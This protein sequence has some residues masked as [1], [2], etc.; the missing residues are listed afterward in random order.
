MVLT[1]Y[2]SAAVIGR[3]LASVPA[4][5]PCVVVDNGGRDDVAA[6]VRAARP[7]ARVHR[8]SRN[9]GFGAGCNLGLAAAGTEFAALLNPDAALAPGCLDACLAAADA[10]PRAA[11]LGADP[12]LS[13]GVGGAPGPDDTVSGA[14][15]F[16]RLAAIRALG[17]F[18]ERFFLYFED[19]DLCLRARAAGWTVG[20]APGAGVLH[21]GG[22]STA[23]AA[24]NA[25]QKE[26]LLEKERLW[27]GSCAWFAAKHAGTP[28]GEAAARKLRR[29]ALK[30]L[31]ARLTLRPAAARVYA[32]RLAGARLAAVRGPEALADNLF[33]RPREGAPA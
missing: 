6:A 18:D 32:A 20:T 7:D 21:E 29:Y 17:G 15:M 3:A 12:A 4:G 14:F 11:V 1:A 25:L 16:L 5:V 26:R 30:A 23:P 33:A 19:A 24:D 2:G 31:L 9:R 27:G 22:A 8:A 28:P 10:D 13:R